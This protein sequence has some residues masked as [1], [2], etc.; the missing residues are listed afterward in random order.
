[1]L[2][3]KNV[4]KVFYEGTPNEKIALNNLNLTVKNHEFVTIVG[5]NGAGKSTLFQMIS[6]NDYVTSGQIFLDEQPITYRKEYERAK[7]I[8]YL[9]QNPLKGTSPNMTILENLAL[10]YL[11]ASDHTSIFSRVNQKDRQFFYEKLKMLGMGLEDRM[12]VKVGTLS[13]GQRQALTLLMAT[14]VPPKLLLLDEHTAALDPIASKKILELTKQ[15]VDQEQIAC[16]MITHNLKD[17]IAFGNRMLLM[18][19]GDILF[20][21]DERTKQEL[22]VHALLKKFEQLDKTELLDDRLLLSKNTI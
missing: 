8:G 22:T 9:F 3:C 21:F 13:G 12:D 10:A 20:D 5:G 14:I 1:M 16:M 19:G 4:R 6:G 7:S 17:A 11:R 2:V 18:D 15:I